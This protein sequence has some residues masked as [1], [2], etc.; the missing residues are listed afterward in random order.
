MCF[1]DQR[2]C[3]S[4]NTLNRAAIYITLRLIESPWEIN[5]S[6]IVHVHSTN[7]LLVNV[8]HVQ[9]HILN[10][11]RRLIIEMIVIH[12]SLNELQIVAIF[13]CAVHTPANKEVRGHLSVY[14]YFFFFTVN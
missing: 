7:L 1:Q 6:Y 2:T 9:G 4:N 8:Q 5:I 3:L 12:L 14:L 11:V 10:T 13:T